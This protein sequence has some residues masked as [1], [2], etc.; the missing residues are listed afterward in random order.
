MFL[1]AHALRS[2]IAVHYKTF[3]DIYGE[4]QNRRKMRG[5]EGR[6]EE[7]RKMCFI[8]SPHFLLLPAKFFGNNNYDFMS[9]F[10]RYFDLRIFCSSC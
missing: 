8:F 6:K 4:G 2:H 10:S 1:C 9:F 7:G 3:Q 5:K